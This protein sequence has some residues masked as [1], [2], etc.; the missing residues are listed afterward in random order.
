[1]DNFLVSPRF[2]FTDTP[3]TLNAPTLGILASGSGSNFERIVEAADGGVLDDVEIAGLVCNEPE[4]GCLQRA[5]RLGV[6]P[7]LINHRDFPD[8]STF[9]AE[10]VE[11]LKT[12]SVDWV[13]MAGWM[14]IVTPAFIEAYRNRILNIHPSL[15][16]SFPGAHAVRD[17]L[18]A[19][20]RMTGCTVHIVTED[21]DDGPIIGQ[22]AVPVRSDD[23]VEALQERI[24][25]A[26]HTLYPRAIA[27]AVHETRS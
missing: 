12:W 10:V 4:A 23:D 7:R 20:V 17:A 11:Q 16:P 13:I 6:A 18:E 24:H 1:V 3:P 8:R 26:E 9:D 15:L 19:G 27:W 21:V 5:R 2:E 22:A 25:R 14:R